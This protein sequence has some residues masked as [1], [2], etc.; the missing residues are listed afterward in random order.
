MTAGLVYLTNYL[1]QPFLR[2]L[3][4]NHFFTYRKISYTKSKKPIP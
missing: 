1:N 3:E 4:K 2:S